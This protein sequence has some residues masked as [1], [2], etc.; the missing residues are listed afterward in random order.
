MWSLDLKELIDIEYQENKQHVKTQSDNEN[1]EE[2]T[3][4]IKWD[5]VIASSTL[6][7]GEYYYDATNVLDG[8]A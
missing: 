6:K 3:N 8:E 4:Y 1:T 5:R 7:P 2:S